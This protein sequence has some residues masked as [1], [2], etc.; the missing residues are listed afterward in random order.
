[1]TNWIST[2]QPCPCGQSSD[3]YSV[4][5]EGAG[6]CF[7][8]NKHFGG[9]TIENDEKYSVEFVPWRGVT[10]E[11]M[12]FYN[13]LTK[14]DISQDSKPVSI[15]FPYEV[16]DSEE[17]AYKVRYLHE[18]AFSSH[19]AMSKANCFGKERF[20]RNSARAITITE[21]ELDAMSVFQMTGSKYPCI[22]VRSAVTAKKDCAAIFEYLDSFEKIYL[23][24]DMDNVGQEAAK[25]VA[26]LF[27]FNK[28]Y[29]VKMEGHKDANDFLQKG[30]D[31]EFRD[32]WFGA[33]RFIPEGIYSSKG[34]FR[35]LLEDAGSRV[36]FS[37]P[38]PT[39]E[40]MLEGLA[41]GETVLFTAL[42]GRGKTEIL[43]AIEYK[44]LKDDPTARIGVIHLEETQ[45]RTIQGFAGYE[46]G[47]P[48]HRR[49][50]V[51]SKYDIHNALDRLLGDDDRLH[52]YGH[53]GSDDPDVIIN[54]IRFLVAVCGCKYIFLDHISIVVSGLDEDNERKALDKI[55]TKLAMLANDLEFCLV[56]VS[57]VNDH[58]QTRGSR[59]I[60][61]VAHKWVHL[62]RDIKAADE[63]TRNT[64]YL[65]VN[66]NRGGHET[67]P[68]GKLYFDPDTYILKEIEDDGPNGLP[69][70]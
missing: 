42:E 38:F 1:M 53:F 28:I 68:A 66:K 17:P 56:L 27:D 62:D 69:P 70:V 61:K 15:G 7:S 41:F 12:E 14:V 64:T 9:K 33:K 58:G 51:V 6:H 48:V 8:C 39:L 18:K 40:R 36:A 24:F 50:S 22:S 67:G 37:Y 3:A 19:G 65:T 20:A 57:H 34:E 30:L 54:T 10:R 35:K 49:G 13:V 55:S 26:T 11:T 52:I 29:H 16:V 45:A 44:I 23:C 47:Q 63:Q 32:L 21:G 5:A 43:R 4:N 46:L 2:H 60:S 59:N 31:K 25:S